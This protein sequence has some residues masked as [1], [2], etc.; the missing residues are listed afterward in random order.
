MLDTVAGLPIHPLVVHATVVIVPAAALA[1]ALAALWPRFRRWAGVGPLALAA[2]AVVLV[3]GSTQSGESLEERVGESALVEQHAQLG[4]QLLPWVLV[5]AV[6]A[7]AIVLLDRRSEGRAP[8][9]ARPGVPVARP[10]AVAVTVLALVGA[11]GTSVQVIRIGHSGAE[12][13][14]SGLVDSTSRGV[15][16]D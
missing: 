4:D 14:W 9:S 5:L 1:V 13:A 11:L 8:F 10:L 16:T 7:A 12:A 2:V 6:A 3:P 15:D